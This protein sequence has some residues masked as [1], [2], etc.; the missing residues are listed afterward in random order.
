M[1]REGVYSPKSCSQ[2]QKLVVFRLLMRYCAILN[3]LFLIKCF[4]FFLSEE[5]GKFSGISTAQGVFAPDATP[6]YASEGIPINCQSWIFFL[7]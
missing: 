1:L 3:K 4:V 6:S 5:N 2:F 7:I